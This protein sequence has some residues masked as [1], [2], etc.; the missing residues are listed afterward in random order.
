[1][2]IR[3]QW[4]SNMP[5]VRAGNLASNGAL[6]LH[7]PATDQWVSGPDDRLWQCR[8]ASAFG[9]V[10]RDSWISRSRSI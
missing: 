3:K 4:P 2:R 8:T 9:W 1:M 5:R 10:D 7:R 6:R